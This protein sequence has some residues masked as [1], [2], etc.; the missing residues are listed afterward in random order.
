MQNSLRR[1]TPLSELT[2]FEPFRNLDEIFN[3]F[4]LMPSIS[5][6]EIIEPRIKIDVMETE[7]A[8]IIKADAPG[9]E[10]E[11]ILVSVDG[12]QITIEFDV[13][14]EKDETKEGKVVRSERYVGRQSRSFS[15]AKD[16]DE[17]RSEAKYINGVLEL[18]LPKKAD[19]SK[20]L[21]SI[22]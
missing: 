15:L 21:L 3:G 14:T 18:I 6:M 1:I 11:D 8:Y 16:V 22:S 13:K 9:V 5:N 12:N 10:K 19:S 7:E 17:S 20:K 2:R 4:R